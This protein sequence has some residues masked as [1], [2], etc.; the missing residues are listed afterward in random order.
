MPPARAIGMLGHGQRRRRRVAVAEAIEEPRQPSRLVGPR[1]SRNLGNSD[2]RVTSFDCRQYEQVGDIGRSGLPP[3]RRADAC[4]HGVA[5]VEP[6]RFE[7]V[8]NDGCLPRICSVH[9][10]QLRRRGSA[11]DIFFASGGTGG[12]QRDAQVHSFSGAHAVRCQD[13]GEAAAC[14][15]QMLASGEA[16]GEGGTLLPRPVQDEA[17]KAVDGGVHSACARRRRQDGI[18]DGRSQC[19]ATA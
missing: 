12:A 11:N 14:G 4:S 19:D 2:C 15:G 1:A 7:G 9:F 10:P 13:R 17:H 16:R 5:T 8:A 6:V 3:Q 18:H